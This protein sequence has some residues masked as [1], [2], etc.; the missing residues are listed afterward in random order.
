MRS[1]N[2]VKPAL[3]KK[4]QNKDEENDRQL[5]DWLLQSEARKNGA[6]ILW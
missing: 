1:G 4:P 5:S 2:G 6:E 3:Y